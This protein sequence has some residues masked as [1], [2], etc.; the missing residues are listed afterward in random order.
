MKIQEIANQFGFPTLAA[1]AKLII[2]G[3]EV[4][5]YLAS[6]DFRRNG[7]AD[8]ITDDINKNDTRIGRVTSANS[9]F[10][11]IESTDKNDDKAYIYVLTS[12]TGKASSKASNCVESWYVVDLNSNPPAII[13]GQKKTTYP[14]TPEQIRAIKMYLCKT[15][16]F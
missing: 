13:G 14:I 4:K 2:E 12:P 15:A 16:M 10:A 6:D 9:E 7:L 1:N 5:T 3:S 11:I 8:I